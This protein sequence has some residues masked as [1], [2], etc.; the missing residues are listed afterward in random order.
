MTE[1]VFSDRR[2][3]MISEALEILIRTNQQELGGDGIRLKEIAIELRKFK[4]P[5]K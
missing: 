1:V 5:S 4:E 2:I 3:E